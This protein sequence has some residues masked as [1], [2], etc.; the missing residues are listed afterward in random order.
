MIPFQMRA[1]FKKNVHASHLEVQ[2]REAF[3]WPGMYK[4]IEEYVSKCEVCNTYHKGQQR[5]PMISNTVPS[6]PWQ[7]LSV[8]L[9]SSR[10][11]TTL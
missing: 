7:A 9:L 1:E 4:E 5:E 3:Y 10:A 8:D 11:R 2:A 6:R